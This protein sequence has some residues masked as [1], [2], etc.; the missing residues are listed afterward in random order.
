MQ[1]GFAKGAKLEQAPGFAQPPALAELGPFVL[2]PQGLRQAWVL[3]R[4]SHAELYIREDA[5]IS[6]RHLRVE[7]QGEGFVVEDL[8]SLN[9][10]RINERTIEPGKPVPL[11][12]GDVLAVGDSRFLFRVRRQASNPLTPGSTGVL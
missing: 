5:A 2:R 4:D 6:R 9:G 3:G 12:D 8:G 7:F 11:R 10:S 1:D